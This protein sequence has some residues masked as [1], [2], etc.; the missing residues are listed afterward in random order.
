VR[1]FPF[2]WSRAMIEKNTWLVLICVTLL[3]AMVPLLWM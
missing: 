3:I 1:N 2:L